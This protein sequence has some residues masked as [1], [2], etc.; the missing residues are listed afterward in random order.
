V[1]AVTHRC[2]SHHAL[3]L[4]PGSSLSAW[5]GRATD[6]ASTVPLAVSEILLATD[7]GDLS[8]YALVCAKQIAS[9]R[10][11]A[12][13][14]VHVI[15]LAGTQSGP[16]AS[17]SASREAAHRALR[18]IQ[19]ELRVAGVPGSTSV[20]NTGSRARAIHDLAS[21]SHPIML[22]LGMDAE[23]SMLAP[24]LGA[25]VK[26]ILRCA[27]YPV[28]LPSPPPAK[29][30]ASALERVLYLTDTSPQSLEAAL[31]SWPAADNG[32]PA[33]L[34]AIQ[35]P[36]SVAANPSPA[37]PPQRYFPVQFFPFLVSASTIAREIAAFHPELIVLSLGAGSYLDTFTPGGIV[38]S[39]LTRP[40]CNIL[41]VKT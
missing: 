38:H 11:A 26:S 30:S 9:L 37:I 1:I 34:I 22:I 15:D 16:V 2:A 6:I 36:A 27:T 25:T 35:P 7:L 24:S 10:H 23:R 14:A 32:L 20:L 13:R 4:C 29:S 3:P 12:V 8:K 33:P 28:L 17:F 5:L 19:H 40:P 41:V 31:R 18:H 39:L 21:R